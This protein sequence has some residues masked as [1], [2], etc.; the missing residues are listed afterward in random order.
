MKKLWDE[1]CKRMKDFCNEI[2]R[3]CIDVLALDGDALARWT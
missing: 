2:S 3:L 1:N